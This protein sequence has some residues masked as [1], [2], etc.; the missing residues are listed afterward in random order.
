MDGKQGEV[1]GQPGRGRPAV[2]DLE[3]DQRRAAEVGR[4][5][6]RH[7]LLIMPPLP[8]VCPS[9]PAAA[10]DGETD[11]SPSLSLSRRRHARPQFL[12][13]SGRPVYL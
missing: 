9:P 11:T 7:G 5:R 6:Q 10:A 12:G 2:P 3:V 8:F 1:V 13:Y 4:P